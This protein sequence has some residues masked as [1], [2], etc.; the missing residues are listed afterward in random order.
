MTGWQVGERNGWIWPSGEKMIRILQ[1]VCMKDIIYYIDDEDIQTCQLVYGT[2]TTHMV[3]VRHVGD[4]MGWGI[5]A[6]EDIGAGHLIYSVPTV[7]I[8]EK[9]SIIYKLPSGREVPLKHEIYLTKVLERDAIG[10]EMYEFTYFDIFINSS[11]DPNA[12]YADTKA[13]KWHREDEDD[14]VLVA[15]RKIRKGE[16]VLVDYDG[17]DW[18]NPDPFICLCGH[19]TCSGTKR[20]F[21]Y[22]PPA[23]QQ[24]YLDRNIVTDYVKEHYYQNRNNIF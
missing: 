18:V 13:G 2:Y 6:T 24:D 19:S 11:C 8:S 20:G 14:Q 12:S 15:Q 10:D 4:K 17:I 21:A 23:K 16:Q 7:I 3:E 9:S 22:L 5:F 1:N